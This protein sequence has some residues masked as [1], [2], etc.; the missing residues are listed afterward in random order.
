V[1]ISLNFGTDF[2]NL[3]FHFRVN[4]IFSLEW[5]FRRLGISLYIIDYF[6]KRRGNFHSREKNFVI[7]KRTK[8]EN[9]KL[10]IGLFN[11]KR[12]PPL[13]QT[14]KLRVQDWLAPYPTGEHK[15]LRKEKRK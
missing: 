1:E 6:E 2:S 15:Y 7:K 10:T 13:N 8:R 3:N 11:S 9:K 14:L 12:G 5:K 4:K